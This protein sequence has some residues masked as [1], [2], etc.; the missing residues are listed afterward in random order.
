[1]PRFR[2]Q[3]FE[4]I[5]QDDTRPEGFLKHI[6]YCG[7]VCYKT[8]NSITE[9]SYKSFVE[10]LVKSGHHAVL[11]HGTIYL[12]AD[13]KNG[14]VVGNYINNPY[15]KVNIVDGVAYITTNYRVMIEND[16]LDDLKYL[17]VPTPYHALRFTVKFTMDRG[18]SQ[19]VCRHRKM[20]FCQE[21]T[22]YC[23]YSKGKFGSEIGFIIPEKIGRGYIKDVDFDTA[24]ALLS[25]IFEEKSLWERLRYA[26]K[27]KRKLLK[28]V[29]DRTLWLLSNMV[30]E[31]CYMNLVN[32]YGWKAQEAR[33]VLPMDLSSEIVVTGFKDEWKHFFDLRAVGTTGAP[34]PDIKALAKPLLDEFIRRGI[35]LK[36]EFE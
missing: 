15:S 27:G 33:A 20:S 28:N 24:D 31:R 22:R 5:E 29:N 11:E 9:D 6:E 8:D 2:R 10:R 34:H 30:S 14:S 32:D 18:G 7:R 36:E 23:N 35:F 4:F 26:L 16:F 1:M 25:E 17:T 12:I 21:S 3:T 13:A 19:S